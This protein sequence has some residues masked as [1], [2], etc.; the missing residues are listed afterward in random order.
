M[1]SNTFF[2]DIF[3]HYENWDFK[4]NNFASF[5]LFTVISVIIQF[6]ENFSVFET[7]PIFEAISFGVLVF[8]YL[9]ENSS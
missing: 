3:I 6:L 5:I 2:Y 1:K 9:L 8:C 7:K 4:H